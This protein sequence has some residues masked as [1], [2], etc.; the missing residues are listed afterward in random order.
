MKVMQARHHLVE[1]S[2]SDFFW[3]LTSIANVIKKLTA[4]AVFENDHKTLV[5]G[6]ILSL[7]SGHVSDSQKLYNVLLIKIF[8]DR[9]LINERLKVRGLRLISL[10]G[11]K[12]SFGVFG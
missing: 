4:S 7:V 12:I 3:E 2:A 10:D 5:Y 6:A 8:H 9:Q 11:D 1:I